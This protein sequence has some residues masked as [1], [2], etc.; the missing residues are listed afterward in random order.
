MP[1]VSPNRSR[2]SV[3]AAMFSASWS[4]A[5][6]RARSSKSPPTIGTELIAATGGT[7]RQRSGAIRPRRVGQRQVVDRGREDVRD[8]LRDQL[9]GRGHAD[10]DRLAEAADRGGGLLAECRVRLVADHEL[11]GGARDLVDVAREPGVGLDRD[12]RQAGRLA[13]V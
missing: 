5:A 1:G 7:R 10:V 11:V 6:A 12:R 3:A 9:L 8:L 4:R 13:A 2:Y